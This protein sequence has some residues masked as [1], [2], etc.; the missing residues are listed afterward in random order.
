MSKQLQD[1]QVSE[2]EFFSSSIVDIPFVSGSH[3][4]FTLIICMNLT[5]DIVLVQNELKDEKYI[6]LSRLYSLRNDQLQH[7][8]AEVEQYKVLT[9]SLQVELSCLM[10]WH[11]LFLLVLYGSF[12]KL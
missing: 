5:F 12:L 4:I 9:E 8:N 1:L 11:L 6:R 7:W 10:C 2:I 3:F